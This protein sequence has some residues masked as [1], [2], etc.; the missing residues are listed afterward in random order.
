MLAGWKR[1]IVEVVEQALHNL[2][3]R[4]V[5]VKTASVLRE[6]IADV[7][8]R[9]L[10]S[11][12]GSASTFVLVPE[13]LPRLFGPERRLFVAPMRDLLIGLP[14]N[15]DRDFAAWLHH[16]FAAQDPN[17]LAPLGFAFADGRVSVEALDQPAAIA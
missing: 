7:P 16:E 12:S 17:C 15:V 2:R 6:S 1:G 13:V 9:A 11:G 8:V 3:D 14:W 5:A 4:A 10:Q